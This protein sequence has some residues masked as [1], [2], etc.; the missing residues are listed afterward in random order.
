MAYFFCHCVFS[1]TNSI[2]FRIQFS[3]V[4][5]LLSVVK[6]RPFFSLSFLF[7]SLVYGYSSAIKICR[8][9]IKRQSIFFISYILLFIWSFFELLLLNNL[10][11]KKK[12]CV[13]NRTNWI[14]CKIKFDTDGLIST[15]RKLL[16]FQHIHFFFVHLLIFIL[17]LALALTLTLTVYMFIYLFV[18]LM[19]FLYSRLL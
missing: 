19:L 3:I 16:S 15:T 1:V 14:K 4:Y 5:I 18:Y 9:C 17:S 13:E 2:L 8:V 10:Q 12:N 11:S 6:F 7:N